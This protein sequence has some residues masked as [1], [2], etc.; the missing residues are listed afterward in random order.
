MESHLS[1]SGGEPPVPQLQTSTAEPSEPGSVS[2]QSNMSMSNPYNFSKE[3]DPSESSCVSIKSNKSLVNP[4]DFSKKEDPPESSCVSMKSNKSLVNPYDF[5]K[6]EDPPESSCVSMKRNKSLVN[7]YDF[8]KE[9]D[10][11][12]SSCVSMKSNKSLVNPYDFSKEEDP[13]ESSCVSMKSNKSLVNPYDFSKEEDP[14]ESS[15]VSMK[16]NKSLVNPCNFRNKEPSCVF[17]KS[18]NAVFEPPDLSTGE[19]G[20]NPRGRSGLIQDQYSCGVCEQLLTDPVSITCEH[21]FCRRCINSFWNRTAL[22]GDFICP[23]CRKR[24]R[25]RPALHPHIEESI[26]QDSYQPVD[27]V[28]QRILQKHKTSMKNKYES[29]YEV[30]K[31]PQNRTLLNRIYTQLYI[32]EGES[33]GVNEEHEVLQMER[34]KGDTYRTLQLTAQIFLNL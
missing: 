17:V 20:I 26:N 8:S 10:P 1:T 34:K 9:E 13:P 27:D 25:T 31:T 32:I 16:S 15:C 29:L 2:V 12:E 7:P 22:S 19:P 6:E 3:E 21:S 11:P 18:D 24:S 28:L 4:Y 30:I 14:P 23:C 33:E 5:S